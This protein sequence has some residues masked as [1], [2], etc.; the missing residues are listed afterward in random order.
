MKAWA[1]KK[2]KNYTCSMNIGHCYFVS[3][4]KKQALKWYKISLSLLD[5]TKKFFKEMEQDYNDLKMQ[6]YSIERGD[7]DQMLTE[8]KDAQ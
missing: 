2:G 7:Y 8:L 3:N 4:N 6:D 5:E 1:M